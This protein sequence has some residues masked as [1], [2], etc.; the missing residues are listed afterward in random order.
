VK[1]LCLLTLSVL[2]IG[3]NNGGNPS[4]SLNASDKST[5]VQNGDISK[6]PTIN[7][8]VPALYNKKSGGL[9][10]STLLTPSYILT[11]A[12]CVVEMKDKPYGET[13]KEEDIS[14]VNDIK[15]LYA[16]NPTAGPV[17]LINDR[18]SYQ[19]ANVKKIAIHGGTF[20]GAI[21]YKNGGL[22][23][24]DETEI[25]DLAIVQ[26]E[27]PILSFSNYLYPQLADGVYPQYSELVTAG[28]GLN[29]GSGVIKPDPY[30][31]QSGILR[32][33]ATYID[34][35]RGA[36]KLVDIIKY[37]NGIYYKTCQGDSGGPDF[38]MQ[39]SKL[40]I[41]GV[42]SFGSGAGCG[43]YYSPGTSVSVYA[44]ESWIQQQIKPDG[45]NYS[46][47]VRMEVCSH[48]NENDCNKKLSDI[49]INNRGVVKLFITPAAAPI[50]NFTIRSISSLGT[51]GWRI[52]S[53]EPGACFSSRLTESAPCLVKMNY[54][55]NRFSKESGVL[56]INYLFK[57]SSGKDIQK[58]HLYGYQR[59]P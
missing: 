7:A 55:P 23:I 35:Y 6:N 41:V 54:A 51:E 49:A 28:Y 9:C 14:Q 4:T 13:Y 12:H 5:L 15:I 16:S 59:K 32:T 22:S 53:I 24:I 42:H 58:T 3:C 43:V 2:I 29:S 46:I 1:K 10:S 27:S 39:E 47:K 19:I 37:K 8:M 11:A 20:K 25:N 48:T 56:S 50:E 52:S 36:N 38:L 18:S 26:L 44:Y 34:R 30:K 57:D 45:D 40:I 31:G 17:N 33:A 21:T